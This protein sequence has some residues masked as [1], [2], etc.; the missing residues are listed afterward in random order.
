MSEYTMP[1]MTISSYNNLVV[2]ESDNLTTTAE[3]YWVDRKVLCEQA[4]RALTHFSVDADPEA[5]W[6]EFCSHATS[7]LDK[8]LERSVK[9]FSSPLRKLWGWHPGLIREAQQAFVQGARVELL[10]PF[11]HSPLQFVRTPGRDSKYD[12]AH[13]PDYNGEELELGKAVVA[14]AWQEDYFFLLFP[15]GAYVSLYS[16]TYTKD[17]VIWKTQEVL[18][19]VSAEEL[20]AFQPELLAA[21]QVFAPLSA[22]WGRQA[23]LISAQQ[24]L[25]RI[26]QAAE[27]WGKVIL[28]QD[29]K[30]DLLRRVELFET[31]DPATPQHL[32]LLGPSGAGATLI[33]RTIGE[34]TSC[35]FQSL[36]LT[37]LKEPSIGTSVQLVRDVWQRARTH[38]PSIIVVDRCDA[39]FPR[40]NDAVNDVIANDIVEAFLAEWNGIRSDER[41]WVIGVGSRRDAIAAGILQLFGAEIDLKLPGADDRLQILEQELRALGITVEMPGEVA[42]STHGMSGRDLKHLASAVR[43]LAH[44]A[45]PSR[46]HFVEAIGTTR[47]LRNIRADE[48][49]SWENLALDGA[50]FD[51]LKLISLLLRDSETWRSKGVSIPRSLL[52][53]GPSDTT[54]QLIARVLAEES[55][56]AFLA[57]TQSDLG[58]TAQGEGIHQVNQFISNGLSGT[59]S[60]LFL[61]KLDSIAPETSDAVA[62]DPLDEGAISRLQHG[63]APM[64]A[65]ES[66]LFVVAATAHPQRTDPRI[67]RCFQETMSLS[68][69]DRATRIRL[70]TKLL[71]RK[72][73]NFPIDDGGILLADLTEGRDFT[74]RDFEDWVQGAEQRALTR[75]ARGGAPEDYAITL[76]DFE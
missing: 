76:D 35:D 23:Q 36:L 75:A 29:T 67:L 53:V 25:L 39:V 1:S 52:L 21:E 17:E 55:G 65:G 46:E 12:I 40:Q 38:E 50:T 61:D 73:I 11:S 45:E 74:R 24:E 69:P 18:P 26:E 51:R 28:P 62:T 72:R 66:R 68:L 15:T 5:R 31:G 63:I 16:F 44:P 32:L 2:V 64:D 58:V 3:Q 30:R 14:V 22:A 57:V 6:N 9:S 8:F 47:R 49:T 7:F 41:I 71:S 56:S 42:S 70:A 34:T 13:I 4:I 10:I 27:A 19:K 48:V 43:M 37:D 20:A 54:A 60:V 33:G 59:S